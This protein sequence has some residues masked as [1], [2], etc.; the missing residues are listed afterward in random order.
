MTRTPPAGWQEGFSSRVWAVLRYALA[1]SFS[2][3]ES[4]SAVLRDVLADGFP[5][6]Q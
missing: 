2:L 5:P 1:T 6:V 4:P 3:L